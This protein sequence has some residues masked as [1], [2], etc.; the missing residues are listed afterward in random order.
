MRQSG[1]GFQHLHRVQ[2]A[3]VYRP[4]T[5]KVDGREEV[6]IPTSATF[7]IPVAVCAPTDEVKRTLIGADVQE[8]VAI[9]SLD[10]TNVLRAKDVIEVDMQDG[11]TDVRFEVESVN[12]EVVEMQQATAI[13][14]AG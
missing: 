14:R 4:T 6:T 5:A 7:T 9:K 10:R 11:R 12:A 3:S 13:V 8:V 2:T 1:G